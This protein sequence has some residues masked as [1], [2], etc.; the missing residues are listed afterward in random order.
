MSAY[1]QKENVIHKYKCT[2]IHTHKSFIFSFL[3]ENLDL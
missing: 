2:N 3:N 1:K